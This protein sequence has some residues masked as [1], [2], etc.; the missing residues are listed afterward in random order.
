MRAFRSCRFCLISP[1]S[2]YIVMRTCC[3]CSDLSA[4]VAG[5]WFDID[6]E[7]CSI[8]LIF[9]YISPGVGIY[10]VLVRIGSKET[11]I[12]VSSPFLHIYV[13]CIVYCSHCIA[14]T[15]AIY[16]V[17]THISDS[18]AIEV[19]LLWVIHIRAKILAVADTIVVEVHQDRTSCLLDQRKIYIYQ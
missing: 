14:S 2:L 12:F 5:S 10:I 19:S 4:C 16:V 13:S 6:S 15:V 8:F 1:R 7:W 11:I 9:A 3:L 17:V 18:V